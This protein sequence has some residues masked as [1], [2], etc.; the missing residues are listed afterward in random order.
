M[1]KSYVSPLLAH[2]VH[3]HF[4]FTLPWSAGVSVNQGVYTSVNNKPLSSIKSRN[5]G[6]EN[7][8]SQPNQVDLVEFLCLNYSFW[9]EI[10]PTQADFA[11][12]K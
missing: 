3:L 4:P 8:K 9:E 7:R 1:Q 2:K 6:E 5:R 12:E 11:T 10:I